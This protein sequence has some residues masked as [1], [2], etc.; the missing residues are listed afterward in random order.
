LFFFSK[1]M[2]SLFRQYATLI[3]GLALLLMLLAAR[4]IWHGSLHFAFLIWNIF[5]AVLPLAASHATVAARNR[6]LACCCAAFW[7]LFFPNA[8]YLLTDI[9]HLQ[10][11]RSTSFW[12]DLVVLFGVALFGVA[13]AVRSLAQMESWYTRLLS[14]RL[15]LLLT[16]AILFVSGYGIYLGRVERWNSWDIICNTG[17]LLSAI[18]YDLRHPFRCS[19]AWALSAVFAAALGLAYLV[20]GRNVSRR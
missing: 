15:S 12:L 1:K 18:A 10:V 5:L 2:S 13:V 11:R 6:K 20:L 17:A 16:V 4:M 3:V 19:E 7:L 9:V 14:P 8:A